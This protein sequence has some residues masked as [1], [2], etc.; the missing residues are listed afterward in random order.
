MTSKELATALRRN[1]VETGS[2]ICLGCGH[3]HN[4][5]TQGCAV[6][7]AAVEENERISGMA[8]ELRERLRPGDMLSRDLVIQILEM[9]VGEETAAESKE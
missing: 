3:E 8:K 7:R 1:M 4:C 6:M 2:L 5:S 9:E